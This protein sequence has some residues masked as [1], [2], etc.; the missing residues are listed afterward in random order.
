M[1]TTASILMDNMEACHTK[2]VISDALSVPH[3]LPSQWNKEL[4]DLAPALYSIIC[5]DSLKRQPS[6]EYLC[7]ATSRA[8]KRLTGWR[9]KGESSHSRSNRSVM[10]MTMTVWGSRK[11]CEVEA[12]KMAATTPRLQVQEQGQLLPTLQ[13]WSN[14]RSSETEDWTI[15]IQAPY[16]PH[17]K[18]FCMPLIGQSRFK[19]HMFHT[20][21]YSACHCGNHIW[22][23]QWNTSCRTA[24]I[25]EQTTWLT[26]LWGKTP[27]HMQ[28]TSELHGF[29]SE[30]M[31]KMRHLTN[32]KGL[33]ATSVHT[34]QNMQ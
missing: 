32:K 28:R 4:G 13:R 18:I 2:G 11:D 23:C 30:Q 31:T 15:K 16:V 21:K 12:E 26:H 20:E 3:V 6:S 5:S 19:H 25:W 33:H 14:D 10:C 24:R 22:H 17:W 9:R 8:M 7:T 1:R 34:L 27:A 29:L